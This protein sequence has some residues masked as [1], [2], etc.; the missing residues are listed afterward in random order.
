MSSVSPCV[1]PG[2]ENLPG[3]YYVR[4]WDRGWLAWD[5][6]ITDAPHRSET[7]AYECHKEAQ[8]AAITACLQT[9]Q[10]VSVGVRDPGSAPSG[11][12]TRF[13]VVSWVRP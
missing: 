3:P 6:S 7:A 11:V 8:I 4:V 5:G 9:H 12:L 10:P 2:A 1:T 13:L